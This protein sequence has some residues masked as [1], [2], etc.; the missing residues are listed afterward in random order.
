[1]EEGRSEETDENLKHPDKIKQSTH[2]PRHNKSNKSNLRPACPPASFTHRLWLCD[3]ARLIDHHFCLSESLAVDASSPLTLPSLLPLPHTRIT[4]YIVI[5]CLALFLPSTTTVSFVW[6]SGFVGV[7]ED[8]E[9]TKTRACAGFDTD[10]MLACLST[11]READE[12]NPQ[13]T[14]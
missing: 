12:P 6:G 13:Q 2:T 4:F 9:P 1:M 11:T 7:E 8:D 3:H 14:P 10:D 5:C